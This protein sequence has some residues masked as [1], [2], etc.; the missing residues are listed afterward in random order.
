LWF[1][2]RLAKD[3][4]RIVAWPFASFLRSNACVSSET[5]RQWC[6]QVCIKKWIKTWICL[7]FFVRGTSDRRNILALTWTNALRTLFLVAIAFSVMLIDVQWQFNF[8]V[9]IG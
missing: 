9:S 8:K 6:R 1:S 5:K 7:A 2:F 4:L 3:G